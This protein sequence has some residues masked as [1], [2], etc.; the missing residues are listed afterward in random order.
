MQIVPGIHFLKR[1]LKNPVVAIGNFDGVHLGHC[2][3]LKKLIEK[4]KNGT[5]VV[6]TFRPH[7]FF[8][9]R[10]E[11]GLSLLTSYDERSKLIGALGVDVLI[12]EPFSREFSNHSADDFFNL[13]LLH[14]L[15]AQAIVVGYDFSFGKNRQGHL[16][17]LKKFCD[18]AHVELTVIPPFRVGAEVVSSTQIRNHLRAGEIELANPLLG[19]EFSYCGDV[20][21]GEARG[22]QIGFPTANLKPGTQGLLLLPSGVYAT[23]TKVGGQLY[24]S[25]TNIGVRP[26]FETDGGLVIETHLLDVS[27]DLYGAEITVK[28]MKRLRDEKKFSGAEE[29]KA[30]IRRDIEEA[31]KS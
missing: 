23:R 7:P 26:T 22:S 18:E 24:P 17:A 12:E 2:K 13:F 16:V 14:Q 28:F 30:Q 9:L 21:R 3:I 31:R 19:R 29:L 5:S 10:P 27:L 1:R 20:V 15:S 6:Y 8:V 11:S 25:V 4:S